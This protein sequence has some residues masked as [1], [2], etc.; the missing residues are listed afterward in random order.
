[1]V[2]TSDPLTPSRD[3]IRHQLHHHHH[4]H[5]SY[6]A[7]HVP[8]LS[9]QVFTGRIR[10]PKQTAAN[11]IIDA[12]SHNSAL[13]V[14]P[15]QGETI[16]ADG[17][18]SKQDSQLVS[19]TLTPQTWEDEVGLTTTKSSS[20]SLPSPLTASPIR[21]FSPSAAHGD[22]QSS[23]PANGT[24]NTP[25]ASPSSAGT[26][27][28][29]YLPSESPSAG[30]GEEKSGDEM[31]NSVAETY[32]QRQ[33]QPGA[34]DLTSDHHT[35]TPGRASCDQP[36]SSP[37]S[38]STHA[39]SNLEDTPRGHHTL[40]D[41]FPAPGSVGS[42]ASLDASFERRSRRKPTI[43]D[44]V[45]RVRPPVDAPPYDSEESEIEDDML[46]DELIMKMRE[47]REHDEVDGQAKMPSASS[48]NSFAM[49]T[50]MP[51]GN[52]EAMFRGDYSR[53]NVKEGNNNSSAILDQDEKSGRFG[54]PSARQLNRLEAVD[55]IPD[56]DEERI[57]DEDEE[58]ELRSE[59][60]IDKHAFLKDVP[61]H[62][63]N[64]MHEVKVNAHAMF[65]KTANC[66]SPEESRARRE[67]YL[68]QLL[69]NLRDRCLDEGLK[70][71]VIASILKDV[72]VEVT[73]LGE[74]L[75]DMKEDTSVNQYFSHYDKNSAGDDMMNSRNM[76]DV[77][78]LNK[79]ESSERRDKESGDGR[80]DNSRGPGYSS[81]H[82]LPSFFN[83][84]S[85]VIPP[86]TSSSSAPTSTSLPP[87]PTASSQ[88]T[89]TP[90]TSTSSS[91]SSSTSSTEGKPIIVTVSA[92][93]KGP[94][95]LVPAGGGLPPL[96]PLA[97]NL[98]ETAFSPNMFGTGKLGPW[99]FPGGL[100]NGMPLYPFR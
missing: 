1:M 74:D 15:K 93:M 65:M 60:D 12:R 31:L 72:E 3:N 10:D 78:F 19:S 39:A 73:L 62:I 87:P 14:S 98:S 36:D 48:V 50:A 28:H 9:D 16:T 33:Q 35:E 46:N 42:G 64:L 37:A 2:A 41:R 8:N 43:E 13:P 17:L 80:G 59:E 23:R 40:S 71:E 27:P 26:S 92:D 69:S 6:Q 61:L 11:M 49:D 77:H 66:L 81:A 82:K 91:S 84:D 99:G 70:P 75:E 97:S 18:S 56:E 63:Y 24:L 95:P 58:M 76:G 45:R 54:S 44:I 4:H 38:P 20:M 29:S 68:L 7:P 34:S 88:P 25:S 55:G 22:L 21:S 90:P 5:A 47:R 51:Q 57:I 85:P 53:S 83:S 32:Q 52:S 30:N 100:V 89:S 79:S 67:Q 86:P 96:H 94:P